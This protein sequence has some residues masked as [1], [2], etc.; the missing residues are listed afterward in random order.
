MKMQT[1][2]L[3]F[4]LLACPP[5]YA[6]EQIVKYDHVKLVFKT[7]PVDSTFV[8]KSKDSFM[9]RTPYDHAMDSGPF[10]PFI[11]FWY[12][13][14]PFSD[15]LKIKVT[16]FVGVDVVDV[17]VEPKIFVL[18]KGCYKLSIDSIFANEG[19]IYK[20]DVHFCDSTFSRKFLSIK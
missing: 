14:L 6:N 13:Y 12:L 2:F 15:T 8:P 17:F 9:S 11:P 19:H 16:T 1:Y 5:N 20:I 3:L 4:C 10:D 18:Q 7:I